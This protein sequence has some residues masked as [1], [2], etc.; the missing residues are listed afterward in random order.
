[1]RVELETANH[2]KDNGD[3]PNPAYLLPYELCCRSRNVGRQRIESCWRCNCRPSRHLYID[4]G[5]LDLPKR[6]PVP[7]VANHLVC[8]VCGARNSD[9]YHPI[10]ARPDAR[11]SSATGQYPDYNKG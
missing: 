3:N 9:T 8:S 11:A 4:A 5:S 2:G 6:M 7:D 10:W 1:M